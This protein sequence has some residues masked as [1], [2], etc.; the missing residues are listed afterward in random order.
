MTLPRDYKITESVY[1]DECTCKECDE[2]QDNALQVAIRG[3]REV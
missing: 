1:D 2:V 3:D